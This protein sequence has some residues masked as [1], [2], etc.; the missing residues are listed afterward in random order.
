MKTVGFLLF[1]LLAGGM[2]HGQAPCVDLTKTLA[3]QEDTA[4]F[5]RISAAV[6]FNPRTIF[7]YVSHDSAVKDRGGAMSLMCPIGT[8][9]ER[10]IVY[11]PDL[12]RGDAV[13]DFVFAHE[14]AHH[15]NFQL[16]SGLAGGKEDELQADFNGAQ[17]LLR[18]GWNREQLVHALDLLNLPQGSQ[19]GYP[20][21]E[22]RKARVE[23]AVDDYEQ[24]HRRPSPPT[25]V[26]GTMVYTPPSYEEN[27]KKFLDIT[28]QGPILFQSVRTN[29][30]VCAIGAP[31]S[32]SPTVTSFSLF[33]NC[34]LDSRGSFE[35]EVSHGFNSDYWILQRP[36]C[37][38]YAFTCL[39]AWE[40]G[41]NQLQFWNQDFASYGYPGERE[42]FSFEASNPSEGLFRIKV[43]KGGFVFVDP[44]T[45]K[46]QSGGSREQAAEFKVL[47]G[48]S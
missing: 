45:A 48:P 21:P 24:S 42:L 14:I 37:P 6:G 26:G 10:W 22:E 47:F 19:G 33:D 16:L 32:K 35:L 44:K 29:K 15:V 8:G 40:P 4:A 3:S 11:D 38:K 12:V 34:E 27:L 23:E 31:D 1:A 43:H 39:Y 2:A 18:L 7:L 30:Y 17:Y 9:F 5:K 46:L 13:R 28:Y 20:T 41:E 36:P 25:L